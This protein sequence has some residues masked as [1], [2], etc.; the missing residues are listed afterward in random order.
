MS[1]LEGLLKQEGGRKDEHS[2][3]V[4]A[5]VQTAWN[6]LDN[7]LVCNVVQRDVCRIDNDTEEF[8]PALS[9]C[10]VNVVC[11][12]AASDRSLTGHE[13]AL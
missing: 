7:L 13:V 8:S 2:R 10:L 1:L 4:A 5:A 3:L 12:T 9:C 6:A 11:A